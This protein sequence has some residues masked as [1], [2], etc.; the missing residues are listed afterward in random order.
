MDGI[1]DA[2]GDTKGHIQHILQT[3]E[4]VKSLST[5]SV[6]PFVELLERP[7]ADGVPGLP[8][9]AQASNFACPHMR[10]FVAHPDELLFLTVIFYISFFF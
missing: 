2:L 9:S 5:E 3:V 4:A 6:R 8:R 1:S 7:Q 10:H